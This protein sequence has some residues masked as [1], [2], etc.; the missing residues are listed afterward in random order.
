MVGYKS[1]A[2][3]EA[4][5]LKIRSASTAATTALH[6]LIF[7]RE[8]DRRNLQRLRDFP[9]FTFRKDSS[10]YADKLESARKLTIG[11]LI[12]FCNILGLEYSGNKEEIIIRILDGLLDINALVSS[13]DEDDSEE[14]ECESDEI[15]DGKEHRND[16][17]NEASGEEQEERRP[18]RADSIR[19][20]SGKDT[21]PIERWITEFE[22]TA[23]L[24]EWA[25]IQKV[26]FAKKSLSG[27][28]KMFIESEGVVRT[29]KKLKTILQD[30]FSDKVNSAQV[31]EMLRKRKLKKEESLQEYYLA[32]KELASRGKIESEAL[33]QYVI[34][35]V[36]DDTQVGILWGF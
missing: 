34:D 21:Y 18:A 27:P 13:A 3:I 25:E 26:V 22:E 14:D 1:L 30:E 28:A 32:M 33:I 5:K 20:F 23:D 9:G 2:E 4:I 8:G 36:A 15:D 24:F 16:D 10:E 6:N 12:S 31:H 11:D 17:D 7:G 29:W 35:G 19:N